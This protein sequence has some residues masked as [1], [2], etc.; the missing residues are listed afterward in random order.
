[1][2]EQELFSDPRAS[3]DKIAGLPPPGPRI[4]TA[5][6]LKGYGEVGP[7]ADEALRDPFRPLGSDQAVDVVRSDTGAAPAAAAAG[8]QPASE[9][10]PS[11]PEARP[12]PFPGPA[13]GAGSPPPTSAYPPAPDAAEARQTAAANLLADLKKRL[14]GEAPANQGPQLNVESTED[15]IL[16]ASPTGRISRC[17]PSA[18]PSRSP[19]SSR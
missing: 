1:M 10:A 8:D 4:D 6:A 12:T 17:S 19:A 3:L 15:G 18:L 13:S 9:A 11:A 2:S 7:S 16:S 5:A 14:A